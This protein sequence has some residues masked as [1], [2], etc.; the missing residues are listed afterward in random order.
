L[1]GCEGE[2]E[3]LLD[4]FN[5]GLEL[6]VLEVA[7]GEDQVAGQSQL[8]RPVVEAI[9]HGLHA[10]LARDHEDDGVR[11]GH[12]EPRVTEEGALS[13]G[14][15]DVDLRVTPDDVAH[16]GQQRSFARQ[17]L[18][19]VIQNARLGRDAPHRRG[20]AADVQHALDEGGLPRALVTYDDNVTDLLG[21]EPVGH[22]SALLR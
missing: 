13:G 5:D 6:D 14:V 15:D 1:H 20:R 2:L 19:L 22:V 21:F 16:A 7:L 9:G 3:A 17:L 8:H 4:G 11:R 12:R 10:V 18:G